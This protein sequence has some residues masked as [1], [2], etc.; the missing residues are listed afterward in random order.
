M[1]MSIFSH[2]IEQRNRIIFRRICRNT[3]SRLSTHRKYCQ[4]HSTSKQGKRQQHSQGAA[5]AAI[6]ARR[7]QSEID[8]K[9]WRR[10]GSAKEEKGV[11]N[12]SG[13]AGRAGSSPYV[14][15]FPNQNRYLSNLKMKVETRSS[16]IQA[17]VEKCSTEW[18]SGFNRGIWT[19]I[20]YT[21]GA[22]IYK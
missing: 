12:K 1:M 6:S 9:F 7:Q 16:V 22:V 17:W 20:R 10:P 14:W 5:A 13:R 3:S 2:D 19:Q 15:V 8:L 21:F 18:K 11:E 4:T